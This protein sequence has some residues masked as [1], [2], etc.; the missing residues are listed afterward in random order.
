MPNPI[1]SADLLQYA[2]PA[3]LEAY[4]QALRLELALKSPLDY[5]E[6]VSPKTERLPHTELLNAVIVQLL[7]GELRHPRTGEVVWKLA[8]SMPPRHGKSYLVSDHLPAWFE[9]KYPDKY[10]AVV[11]YEAEF[12]KSWGRKAR[13]HIKDHPE[14]GVTLSKE[15]SAADA[16][17][18]TQGG[19]MF[20]AGRGGAITGKG[21]HL[22]IVDDLLK[23]AEEAN[24]PT[25]R[26]SAYD[27]L[28]STVF[29]RREDSV[30]TPIILMATRWHEGDP[31]GRMLEEEP[32]DWYVLNLAALALEGDPL[33]RLPGEALWP[34]KYS[35][36]DLLSIQK[37][38]QRWF[39]AMYQGMPNI[40]GGG[41]FVKDQFR[42][43]APASQGTYYLLQDDAGKL[44]Y[45]PVKECT[46]FMTMD[47]AASKKT[48]ADFSVI[49]TW[50]A[51]KDRRL[52]LVGLR[53]RRLETPD[54]LQWVT[55]AYYEDGAKYI[56]VEEATYGLALIQSLQ[57]NN[58]FGRYVSVRPAKVDTDKIARAIPAGDFI[59]Q[60]RMYFSRLGEFLPTFEH[61]LLQFPNGAHDDQVDTVSMAVHEVTLGAL[62]TAVRNPRT[63]PGT[64]QEKVD[65]LLEKLIKKKAQEHRPRHPELGRF[66]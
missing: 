60:G 43:W 32:D 12:A 23:N 62:R 24:S 64:M 4:E 37:S 10:V 46:R 20:T 56:L 41:I 18:T 28:I 8:V 11:S 21:I 59:R 47:V 55:E 42:Y 35:R 52:I 30:R 58:T 49:T 38:N 17:A 48:S 15:Q 3:E 65:S 61:E 39:A 7:A 16:W 66:R 34:E 26:E 53:R 50:D 22:G 29:T 40:E 6:Y 31:T 63:E 51:T 2:S 27:M 45:L 13:E 36:D 33:Q 44:E 19:M 14:F 25:T 54:Q 5:A 1:I 57:Q 9:T